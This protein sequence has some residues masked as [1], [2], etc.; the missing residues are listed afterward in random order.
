MFA[1]T[2]KTEGPF[3]PSQVAY[4]ADSG[5]NV[6][7]SST[8]AVP[9]MTKRA[10]EKINGV[11]NRAWIMP[12]SFQ[13]YVTGDP[14]F[15]DLVLN[16]TLTGATFSESPASAAAAE[17]DVA[18]SVISS[19]TVV[20]TFICDPGAATIDVGAIFKTNGEVLTRK[21]NVS[22]IADTYSLQARNLAAGASSTIRVAANWN[23]IL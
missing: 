4:G 15:V 16:A 12:T 22:A 9:I 13:T 18:A 21:A 5:I 10:K 2:V 7:V 20:K 6:G 14:V 8:T 1:A 3:K 17:V 23:E 11:P 19:G